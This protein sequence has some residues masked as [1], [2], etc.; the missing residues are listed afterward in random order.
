MSVIIAPSILSADFNHLGAAVELIH[1]S[2]AEW[3]HIDVMDGRFVPNLS[4]GF[5]I[6]E[7]VRRKTDK[8]CDVHLMIE[9]PGRYLSAF[10]KSGAD[11]L[12]I[13]YEGN[14][15]LDRLLHQIKET[16]ATAG[17][18]INPGTP[19]AAITQLLPLCDLVLVMSVNPGF[20]GQQ[21]IPYCLDKVKELSEI[22]QSKGYSAKIQV[23]GGIGPAQAPA[24][25]RAGAQVLVA[26]NA[27]FGAPDPT[28]AILKLQHASH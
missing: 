7:A 27:V 19:V 22:I 5:P 8:I 11:H 24:L 23:D 25:I 13:H 15:H 6:L 14:H 10:R 17:L 18:A 9:E 20:G 3:V 16:G 2:S 28:E 21:F 1:R 4:F 26:G 12:T